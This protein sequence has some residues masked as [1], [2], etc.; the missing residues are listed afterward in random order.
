MGPLLH[1]FDVGTD[2][3]TPTLP[4]TQAVRAYQQ[5][6]GFP[7][8]TAGAVA[9]GTGPYRP[10]EYRRHCTMF[11]LTM[12]D[13]ELYHISKSPNFYAGTQGIGHQ[14]LAANKSKLPADID[15]L[16]TMDSAAALSI[17][18]LQC[19]KLE[20]KTAAKMMKYDAL[21]QGKNTVI[22]NGSHM[23]H[24]RS[25][26]M[27]YLGYVPPTTTD[28]LKVQ[29]VTITL[30]VE[31]SSKWS[32]AVDIEYGNSIPVN[33]L[34]DP[35]NVPSAHSEFLRLPKE[36]DITSDHRWAGVPVA[37]PNVKKT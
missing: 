36:H 32:H 22:L 11:N 27:Y 2:F 12:A 20:K 37:Y 23:N 31:T 30:V 35:F 28:G 13:G 14:Y 25:I 9:D 10:P 34:P 19:S 8:L 7:T 24:Q 17:S 4:A 29:A 1:Q 15:M 26:P 16:V 21:I 6:T 3:M 5:V 33:T 18:N